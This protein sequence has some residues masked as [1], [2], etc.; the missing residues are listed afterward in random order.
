M[1]IQPRRQ[2]LEIW[3]STVDYS[4][5]DGRWSW[6]GRSGRNSISDADQ[7]LTI[8]YP[9]TA[10][11]S[12]SLDSVDQTAEDVSDYLRP[13][14]NVLDIPRR[15]LGFIDD[16]MRTYLVDGVPD[17]SGDTYFSA[18]VDGDEGTITAR[19]RK[20]HVVES[21]ATSINLCLAT[22]AF[23]RGYRQGLRSQR[24][25]GQVEDL[26]EYCSQRL[27]AAMVGLLRCYTVHT[28]DPSELSGHFICKMVNQ[29][30]VAN[31]VLLRSLLIE[32]AEIRAGLRQEVALGSGAA[33]EELDNRGRLFECGWSWGVIDGAPEIPYVSGIG[34]QPVGVAEPRPDLYFTAVALD[35]I[36]D[37]FSERTRLLGLLNEEQQ[38]LARALQLRWDLTRQFWTK[39]AT[40]GDGTWPIEDLPWVTTDGRESDYN[41]VLLAS[42]VVQGIGGE[43]IADADVERVGRL[44]EELANRGRITRR[45]MVGDP[46]IALHLPGMTVPLIGS[47]KA[48][49]GPPLQWVVS[50]YGS[51]ILRRL[52]R[53]AGMLNDPTLRIRFLDLADLIWGHID[54]RKISTLTARGLW[55]EPTQLFEET[56]FDP[57]QLPSWN[58]TARVIEVLVAAAGTISA[59]PIAADGLT[60]HAMLLLAE[61]EQLF[62]QELLRGTHDTGER[63]REAFQV[64]RARLRRARELIRDRPGTASVLASDVLRELDVVDAAR[65]DVTRMT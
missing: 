25:L 23:I 45:P 6:G 50:T 47:E 52:L 59:R 55:D 39:I 54:R 37:L 31:E 35:A 16:Y 65:Q 64:I 27:T 14:G 12:L 22:L 62:D 46:A 40:F 17:F 42:I 1:E 57:Y 58:H 26:E 21:Y 51:L 3:R 13:L 10:I 32:L 9:A 43:R 7:L 34:R 20:L 4:F 56:G 24:A 5:R 36:G 41:S 53:V 30:G 28:F 2:I 18:G 11:E 49:G 48:D 63:M 8:L 33:S 15:L 29:T 19:Q 38:R 60:Q 61:A 44:L